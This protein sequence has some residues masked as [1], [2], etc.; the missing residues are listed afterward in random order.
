MLFTVIFILAF[1]PCPFSDD[2]RC[3]DSQACIR[4]SSWCDQHVDC[5]DGSDEEN[6]CKFKWIYSIYVHTYV[7][8]LAHTYM[9]IKYYPNESLVA[10]YP[11]AIWRP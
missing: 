11:V 4:A 9:Y 7:P 8:I 2:R 6:C 10:Q 1:R 3:N 5:M